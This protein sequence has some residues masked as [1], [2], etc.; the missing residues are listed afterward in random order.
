MNNSSNIVIYILF[1]KYIIGYN[2]YFRKY[3]F[4]ITMGII[5]TLYFILIPLRKRKKIIATFI[6][7]L[8]EIRKY[9]IAYF[10]RI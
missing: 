8:K 10:I 4:R 3:R 2:P 5:D 9:Y 7:S 6:S 1:L